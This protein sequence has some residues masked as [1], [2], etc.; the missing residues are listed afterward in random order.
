MAHALEG[1]G[2]IW[3]GEQFLG[4]AE[5][6]LTPRTHIGTLVVTRNLVDEQLETEQLTLYL[7]DQ[8]PVNFTVAYKCQVYPQVFY[9]IQLAPA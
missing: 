9:R 8:H 4:D 1:I 2:Q 5:Y 6:V 3:T 7:S